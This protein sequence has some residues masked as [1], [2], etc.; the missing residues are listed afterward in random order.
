MADLSNKKERGPQTPG[1]H[2]MQYK[3]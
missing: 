2:H 3:V 1:S